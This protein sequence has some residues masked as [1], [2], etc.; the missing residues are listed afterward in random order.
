MNVSKLAQT[1]L[2]SSS[3]SAQGASSGSTA[4]GKLIDVNGH[5]IGAA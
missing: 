1:D 3:T 5:G 4:R 2:H